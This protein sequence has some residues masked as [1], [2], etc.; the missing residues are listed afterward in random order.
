VTSTRTKQSRIILKNAEVFRVS[1]IVTTYSV[2][3]PNGPIQ[4][5]TRDRIDGL[6]YVTIQ[7]D[8][9]KIYLLR[10]MEALAWQIG[11]PKQIVECFRVSPRGSD[12]IRS[13]LQI[14]SQYLET[15]LYELG[16]IGGQEADVEDSDIP[17][18]EEDL[19]DGDYPF[20]P[21]K[22]SENSRVSQNWSNLD[23]PPRLHTEKALPT[24][25][26]GSA[27]RILRASVTPSFRT[28]RSPSS[29][30][31][32]E[33]YQTDTPGIDVATQRPSSQQS[34]PRE[35]SQYRKENANALR[36]A[37]QEMARNARIDDTTVIGAAPLQEGNTSSIER[38]QTTTTFTE[39]A[40]KAFDMREMQSTLLEV[41]YAGSPMRRSR[42][43]GRS[44]L[45]REPRTEPNDRNPVEKLIGDLGEEF[46]ST[47][48]P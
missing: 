41:S 34:R 7:E 21:S 22:F 26:S 8:S 25:A 11:V 27:S 13:A 47:T 2:E 33:E 24:P 46:V 18:P 38:H 37:V 45:A 10:D 42:S 9:L 48:S 31:S 3:G 40:S 29:I 39:G 4:I 32:T 6:S 19:N 16:V 12:L 43:R 5:P 36:D 15:M 1:S 44:S 30:P 23:T 35:S 17:F 20:A 28:S 14:E